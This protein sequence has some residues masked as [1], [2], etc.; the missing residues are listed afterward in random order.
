MYLHYYSQGACYVN[1]DYDWRQYASADN[2]EGVEQDTS[3]RTR[4]ASQPPNTSSN[5]DT[6]STGFED[7]LSESMV[8]HD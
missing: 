7:T 5:P 1:Q 8:W 6:G 3:L 4:L 2:Q